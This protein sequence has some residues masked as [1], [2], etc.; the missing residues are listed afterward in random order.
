MRDSQHI[1]WNIFEYFDRTLTVLF[2]SKINV[3]LSLAYEKDRTLYA[4]F[5][6]FVC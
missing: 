6:L 3:E 4:L 2:G 1:L 5:G